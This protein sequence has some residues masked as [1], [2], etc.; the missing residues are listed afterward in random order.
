MRMVEDAPFLTA[1][2]YEKLQEELEHLKTV[3]RQEVAE[4]IRSAK[5]E[6]DITE[7]AGYDQAK[8]EQAFL[9]GRIM[10][11][12]RLL[13]T[14]TIIEEDGPA[15]Q[16]RV[17]SRVTVVEIEGHRR[18]S[19]E[20]YRI[21]GSPEADP[22]SGRISNESPLGEALIGRSVGEQVAVSTPGGK[23]RFEI[24]GIA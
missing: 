9:E 14:A 16:V 6:G 1:E 15:D 22:S 2:G 8:E 18:N 24:M 10:T 21:V 5:E 3:R 17:G 7:N 11:L 19:P 4:R 12:E 13:Q 23:I 20:T